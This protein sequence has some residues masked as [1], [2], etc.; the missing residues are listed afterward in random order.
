MAHSPSHDTDLVFGL[1]TKQGGVKGLSEWGSE[2]V[3]WCVFSPNYNKTRMP[4]ILEEVEEEARV[5]FRDGLSFSTYGLDRQKDSGTVLPGR[6]KRSVLFSLLPFLCWQLS[7]NREN[8]ALLVPENWRKKKKSRKHILCAWSFTWV[9]GLLFVC[10]GWENVYGFDMSC[11]RNVAIKEPLVDVVDPKQVVTNACLL[12]VSLH[13]YQFV[14]AFCLQYDFIPVCGT[15][16][17]TFVFLYLL[18]TWI[19]RKSQT[20]VILCHCEHS[21]SIESIF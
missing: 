14:N 13:L 19:P 12:K 11:I 16:P 20:A 21:P 6:V 10:T 9:S 1:L 5:Y 3:F 2:C 8:R 18:V 15:Y 7:R 4:D 17:N